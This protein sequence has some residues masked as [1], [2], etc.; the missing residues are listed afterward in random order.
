VLG[1]EYTAMTSQSR[2]SR[3]ALAAAVGLGVLALLAQGW[4]G[5]AM[6]PANAEPAP[7]AAVVNGFYSALLETM[8]GAKRLGAKGRYDK[9]MPVILSTFDVAGMMRI[10]AGPGWETASSGQQAGLV[11]AFSRMMTATY[12]SRFDDFTGE[13]FEVSPAED[14]PPGN[15]LVRTRLIQSNGK[16]VTLNYLLRTTPAGWKIADVYLDGTIS[17]LTAQRAEY[18]GVMKTGGPDALAGSL[19]QKADKLLGGS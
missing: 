4:V 10:A 19:R 1:A 13:T 7:P 14:Q 17:Q 5:A 9:L 15:K 11:E 3:R 8:K 16:T 12:A 2:P 18:A 6:T